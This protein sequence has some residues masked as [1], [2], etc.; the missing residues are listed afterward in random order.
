[1]DRNAREN[2]AEMEVN[3]AEWG[4]RRPYA[5][6]ETRGPTLI[7]PPIVAMATASKDPTAKVC[8]RLSIS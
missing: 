7:Q 5:I 1:M 2:I 8:S 3:C 4:Y 6:Y